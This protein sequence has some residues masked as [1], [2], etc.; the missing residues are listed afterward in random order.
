M[1]PADDNQF[2][3]EAVKLHANLVSLRTALLAMHAKVEYEALI[4]RLEKARKSD[5]GGRKLTP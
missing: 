4:L 3:R 2:W 1:P 5:Q